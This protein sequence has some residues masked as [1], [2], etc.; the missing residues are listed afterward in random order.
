MVTELVL[1][2]DVENVKLNIAPSAF[3]HLAQLLKSNAPLLPSLLRLRIIQADTSSYFTCLHLLH[4][5]SLKTLEATNVPEHQHSTFFS[6]L[7]TLV[8][9]AP[10]LEDII[11]GPGRFPLKSLQAILKFTHLRQLELRDAASTFDFTFLQDVGALPNLESFILDARSCEYIP[12]EQSMAPHAEH[13]KVGNSPIY[14]NNIEVRS[15]TPK[16]SLDID[17]HGPS[18]TV[19]SESSLSRPHSYNQIPCDTDLSA[20]TAVVGFYQLKRFHFVG[21]LLMIQDMIPYIASST[22]EDISITIIRP[23]A[24]DLKQE[25]ENMRQAEAERRRKADEETRQRIVAMEKSMSIRGFQKDEK[26]VSRKRQA[27]LDD[28]ESRWQKAVYQEIELKPV[29]NTFDLHTALC[30]AILQTVSSRWSASLKTVKINQLDRSFQPISIPPALPKEVYG[31]LFCHPKIET[32]E[33]Q[34]W[35]LDSVE[36]FIFSLKISGPKSLKHLHMPMDDPDSAVSLPRLLDIAEACPMLKSLQCSID[37]LS[38]IPECPI[39]ATK[40]LAHGLQTL[41][42]TSKPTLLYNFNQLLLVARHIYLV[43]PYIQTIDNMEGSNADSAE[44]WVHIHDVVK[45]YQAIREDD[46]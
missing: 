40:A 12:K 15:T 42:V 35:K 25:A 27:I 30:V 7:T 13:T 2:S 10:H 19:Y 45:M 36:D 5:P 16:F 26:R 32:L 31:T 18:Q 20:S 8:H 28:A 34:Q 17:G 43:F 11:L 14:E 23:S 29:Q 37:T 33:F 39:R 46:T 3:I 21:G 4:T 9:K 1:G 24:E 41:T 22:L 44:Q 6:F 38:L